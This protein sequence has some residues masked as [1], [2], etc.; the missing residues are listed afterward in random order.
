MQYM[1]PSRPKVE[2]MFVNVSKPAGLTCVRAAVGALRLSC[3]WIHMYRSSLSKA[4]LQHLARTLRSVTD[5]GC[6]MYLLCVDC[7]LAKQFA[8]SKQ[9]TMDRNENIVMHEYRQ[10]MPRVSISEIVD[11]CVESGFTHES[12]TSG[13]EVLRE[14][15]ENVLPY[16]T[17][18]AKCF[19]LVKMKSRPHLTR[20]LGS[21][22]VKG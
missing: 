13:D 18:T 14:A 1:L 3:V 8:R 22:D 6:V 20:V 9:I 16:D 11:A 4:Q 12:T 7:V 15:H 5:D 19:F 21:L 17:W 10:S 2:L